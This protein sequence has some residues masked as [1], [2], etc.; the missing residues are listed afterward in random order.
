MQHVTMSGKLSAEDRVNYDYTQHDQLINKLINQKLKNFNSSDVCMEREDIINICRSHIIKALE[1]YDP[2]RG[3]KL[4]SYIYMVIDSRLGNM[5]GR[6]QKKNLA[7]T[8]SLSDVNCWGITGGSDDTE[9]GF[10]RYN[11]V[12][13]TVQ[14]LARV[15]D[16]AVETLDVEAIYNQMS[17]LRK[18]L[19]REFFMEGYTVLEL[20]QRHPE[21][22]YHKIRNELKSLQ[23]IFSTLCEGNIL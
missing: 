15:E 16:C 18:L 13:S 1:D 2:S 10:S 5:R 7:G 21:I 17:D 23:K 20:F 19:F 14:E 9:V 22:G 11:A 6:I 4:T 8:V 3:Q 12:K